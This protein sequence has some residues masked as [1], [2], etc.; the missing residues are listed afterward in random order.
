MQCINELAEPFK[1][2]KATARLQAALNAR[3]ALHNSTA[4]ELRLE[5]EALGC[6]EL[7]DVVDPKFADRAD[8]LRRRSLS[9][10]AS[11]LQLRS[12]MRNYFTAAAR[13]L[14]AAQTAAT[15]HYD[16]LVA[17]LKVKLLEIGYVDGRISDDVPTPSIIPIF[18][19]RHPVVHGAFCE[20][21]RLTGMGDNRLAVN[22]ERL[23]RISAELKK[24]RDTA[25]RLAAV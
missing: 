20:V 13:D 21:Q 16:R 5:V 2:S 14:S 6:A 7:V 19:Q 25:T 11:E 12:E 23:E 4:D 15:Q 18:F 22:E 1:V 3:I 17:E 24:L 9:V 10:L 8:A